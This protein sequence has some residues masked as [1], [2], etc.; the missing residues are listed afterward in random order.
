M[1]LLSSTRSCSM[2]VSSFGSAKIFSKSVNSDGVFL[3]IM[4]CGVDRRGDVKCG[5]GSS[6]CAFKRGAKY[7]STFNVGILMIFDGKFLKLRVNMCP[8]WHFAIG[9]GQVNFPRM[10]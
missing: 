5:L 2:L 6:N 4:H 3:E 9:T 1:L 7:R 10:T 8:V